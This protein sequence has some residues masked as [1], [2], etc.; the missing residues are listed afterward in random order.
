MDDS[1]HLKSCERK[2]FR[3][4]KFLNRT[5]KLI[6]QMWDKMVIVIVIKKEKK[7]VT[8]FEVAQT[9]VEGSSVIWAPK[10]Q[11][12]DATIEEKKEKMIDNLVMKK[13]PKGLD[14]TKCRHV[15]ESIRSEFLDCFSFGNKHVERL[16]VLV[17]KFL[18]PSKIVHYLLNDTHK[19]EIRH[20]ILMF[21]YIDH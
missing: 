14:K 3:V 21:H 18:P 2:K 4:A 19:N 15:D 9:D 7:M 17:D 6:H 13:Y 16:K 11:K 1:V 5:T 8:T 20:Q 10:K 12:M